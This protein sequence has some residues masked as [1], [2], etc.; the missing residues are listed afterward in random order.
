MG[1]PDDWT[2]I[3]N[4]LFG[5][6]FEFAR[7]SVIDTGS[8]VRSNTSDPKFSWDLYPSKGIPVK[9]ETRINIELLKE[10]VEASKNKLLEQ[11]IQ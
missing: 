3:E 4:W 6:N 8:M 2:A 10:K 7:S 1:L 5:D 11:E 9:P